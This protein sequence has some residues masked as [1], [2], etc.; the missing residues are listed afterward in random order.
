MSASEGN[1]FEWF[2]M[3]HERS[4]STVDRIQGFSS[5]SWRS[6]RAVETTTE[7]SY[8]IRRQFETSCGIFALYVSA[9][10]N[11]CLIVIM[12]NF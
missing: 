4:N 5:M 6:E 3:R 11:H 8:K 10:G 12:R 9:C 1:R 2:E 7:N